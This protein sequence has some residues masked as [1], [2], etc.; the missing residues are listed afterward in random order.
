MSLHKNNIP[1]VSHNDTSYFLRYA[2][3]RYVKC[4]K[5]MLKISVIFKKNAEFAGKSLEIYQD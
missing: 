5:N 2:H 3:P 1:Q 4:V